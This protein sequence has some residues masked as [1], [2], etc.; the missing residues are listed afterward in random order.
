MDGSMI[1]EIR[2]HGCCH[3]IRLATKR[4]PGTDCFS[5]RELPTSASP[6]ETGCPYGHSSDHRHSIPPS[7]PPSLDI[8]IFIQRSLGRI[9]FVFRARHLR[10]RIAQHRPH[11]FLIVHGPLVRWN[12][13]VPLDAVPEGRQPPPRPPWHQW[14][15]VLPPR[16]PKNP[17]LLDSAMGHSS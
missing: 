15:E 11:N 4:M 3:G 14:R 1:S 16:P 2:Y 17:Q 6:R 10:T 13:G 12:G 5:R 8:L 9:H 7:P